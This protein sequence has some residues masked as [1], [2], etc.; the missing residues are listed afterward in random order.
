MRSFSLSQQSVGMNGTLPSKKRHKNFRK[1]FD[2]RNQQNIDREKKPLEEANALNVFHLIE[3]QQFEEAIL[4]IKRVP[5]EASRPC[6]SSTCPQKNGNLALHEACRY[7]ASVELV[8]ALIEANESAVR[9][10]AEWGYLPLHFSCALNA[11]C[12]VVSKLVATDPSTAR[13]K[14]AN[15][16]RLPLHLAVKHGA[17]ID[18]IMLLLFAY[19]KASTILDRTGQTPMDYAQKL[20]SSSR[21]IVNLLSLA[22]A[23]VAVNTAAFDEVQKAWETWIQET[24]KLH[25]ERMKASKEKSEKTIAQSKDEVLKAQKEVV[26]EKERSKKLVHEVKRLRKLVQGDDD[27]LEPKDETRDVTRCQT[28]PLK[29]YSTKV[30][31]PRSPFKESRFEKRIREEAETLERQQRSERGNIFSIWGNTSNARHD[32]DETLDG[33]SL[34]GTSQGIITEAR[35]PPTANPRPTRNLQSVMCSPTSFPGVQKWFSVSNDYV[36][37][38]DSKSDLHSPSTVSSIQTDLID[39]IPI[40]DSLKQ[41]KAGYRSKR[42]NSLGEAKPSLLD[43]SKVTKAPFA[44]LQ[45]E[46]QDDKLMKIKSSYVA[47]NKEEHSLL[48]LPTYPN[49]AWSPR[50]GGGHAIATVATKNVTTSAYTNR[51]LDEESAEDISS[52]SDTQ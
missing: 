34:Q 23:L 52:F 50:T 14:E 32:D 46:K 35:D 20:S 18:V 7:G 48:D 22:P 15:E 41:P 47:F 38:V 19:P 13:T 30:P 25:E 24:E 1:S 5:T 2:S 42:P 9:A 12:S 10:T 40:K 44:L 26:A 8:E 21:E 6:L 4:L 29:K 28:L 37:E 31:L 17:S 45:S 3:N 33:G 11:P 27:E 39:I 51:L 36:A 49:Q 16:G 43:Q